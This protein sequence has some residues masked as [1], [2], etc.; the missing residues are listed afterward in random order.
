MK[1]QD[2]MEHG[3]VHVITPSSDVIQRFAGAIDEIPEIRVWRNG[4]KEDHY[5]TFSTFEDA[6]AYIEAHPNEC[7]PYPV[8]AFRG[9]EIPIYELPLL[10]Y[11]EDAEQ[12]SPVSGDS[13]EQESVAQTE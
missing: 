7:E 6:K 11:P 1:A 10:I 8:L 12:N 3:Y 4:E 13:K 5:E 9:W 2:T